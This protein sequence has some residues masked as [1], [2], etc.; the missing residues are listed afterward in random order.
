MFLKRDNPHTLVVSMT[1]VKLGDR[2]MLG[3]WLGQCPAAH[4][5]A[6]WGLNGIAKWY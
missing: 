5:H 3:Q 6:G 2:L 1:G 4:A